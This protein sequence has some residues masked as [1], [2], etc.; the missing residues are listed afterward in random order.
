MPMPP[1]RIPGGRKAGAL[2]IAATIVAG[3]EGL[4]QTAYLDPVGIPTICFGETRGVKIGDTAT[5]EQCRAMLAG[6]LVEFSASVDRCLTARVPDE[7]YAAFLSFAYNAGTGNFCRSTLVRKA[8][9]GDLAGACGE[10]LKWDKAR[11]EGG[12]IIVLPGLT[13]RRHNEWSLCLKGAS[14]AEGL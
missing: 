7:S 10:L 8:N 5:V 2:A 14:S 4:R 9:A 12:K 13:T 6:R 3:A 1:I 11:G